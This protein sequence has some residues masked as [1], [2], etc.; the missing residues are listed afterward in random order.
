MSNRAGRVPPGDTEPVTIQELARDPLAFLER[1]VADFGNVTR[2]ETDGRPVTIVNEPELVSEILIA[3]RSNY[4]KTGTP[5]ELMLVPLLGRGLLTT[6]GEQWKEQRSLAQPAFQHRE[7]VTFDV[8]M[9]EETDRLIARWLDGAGTVRLDRDLTSLTLA[10]VARALLGS[11]VSIGDRFGEAVDDA[12][13]FMSHYGVESSDLGGDRQR[14][15]AA[16]TFIDR[17]VGLLI[18]VADA[19]EPGRHDFLARLVAESIQRRPGGLSQTEVRD[20]VVTMLMAGHETTAKSLTWTMWLLG[21]HPEI[22]SRAREEIDVVLADQP[23]DAECLDRLPFVRATFLE[24]MRLYPPVWLISRRAVKDDLLG[25]YLI[26]ENSLVCVSPWL[27][28]RRPDLWS[29][30]TSFNPDRFLQESPRHPCAFLPFSAGPR[31]C[32]GQHFATLEGVLVLSRM[33]Q[34]VDIAIDPD[35]SVE[36]E[37]LVTLRPKNGVAAT[38]MPRRQ[39]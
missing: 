18:S 26:P 17:I 4:V 9:L 6:D 12:N 8:L 31:Q 36:T 30:P 19:D 14:F 24:A 7:I 22:A 25:E 15:A 29:D 33:L 27:L 10:I 3:K 38:V 34:M 23:P 16:R 32:I 21:Q 20:Q 35:H 11:D 2:H 5:D 28:H 39:A 1:M 13:R 37:A